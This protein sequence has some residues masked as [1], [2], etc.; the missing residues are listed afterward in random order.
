MIKRDRLQNKSRRVRKKL[1][2]GEFA[3][4]AQSLSFIYPENGYPGAEAV[5]RIHDRL[6][7]LHEAGEIEIPIIYSSPHCTTVYLERSVQTPADTFQTQ[8][9]RIRQILKN[10]FNLNLPPENIK[11]SPERDIWDDCDDDESD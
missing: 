6:I 11:V 3:Y 2:V 1:Y 5:D 4:L 7:D 9:E 8:G 10:E